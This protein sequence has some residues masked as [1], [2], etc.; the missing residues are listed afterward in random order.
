MTS[1]PKRALRV[2]VPAVGLT[3]A[4]ALSACAGGGTPDPA[5]TGFEGL[6]LT[7]WNNIDFDPYQSLQKGYFEACADELGIT[8]DVQ[9]QSGDYTTSLLQAAS[10]KTLPDVALLS[11]DT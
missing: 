2:A 5:A 1:S 7:V 11:T 9:T 4:L 3:A 10:S 6:E 8:V